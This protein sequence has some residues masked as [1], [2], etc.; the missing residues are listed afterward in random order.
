VADTSEFATGLLSPQH[1]VPLLVKG[2]IER[3]YAVYRNNVTV[4]LVRALE[5][6]FPMVRRLLGDDYFA[7]FA[8]DFAQSNPPQ[9]PL[10][11]QYGEAFPGALDNAEDLAGFPYLGDIAR[12]EILWRASYHAADANPLAGDA[13]AAFDPDSLFDCHLTAHPATRLMS[14]HFAIHDIFAANSG[15]ADGHV[16]DPT[17]PQSVLITRPQ[18]DVTTHLVPADKFGFFCTLMNG[19]SLG[20][21]L[22]QAAARNPEFDLPGTLTLLLQ[23]GAFHSIQQGN[24]KTS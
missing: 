10:M 9:S 13:L 18:M 4:G 7:G 15:S 8:R 22:D 19:E 2:Q 17:Q 16:S 23:S 24:Q 5:D 3:R 20:E 11:F 6:N 21:A 14:S 12:L 1:P